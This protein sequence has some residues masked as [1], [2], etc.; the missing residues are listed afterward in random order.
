MFSDKINI[1]W[2]HDEAF[3]EWIFFIIYRLDWNTGEN[4]V[5]CL[6]II[7]EFISL[8]CENN[9]MWLQ[10]LDWLVLRLALVHS[11]FGQLLSDPTGYNPDRTSSA[12]HLV[13][14]PHHGFFFDC[15]PNASKSDRVGVAGGLTPLRRRINTMR[16]QTL[17]DP[18]RLFQTPSSIRGHLK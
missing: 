8:P 2:S 1:R 16:F 15:V 18:S 12:R 14:W 5:R 6:P 17:L 10:S 11:L 13:I 7:W 9:R 3:V 4:C